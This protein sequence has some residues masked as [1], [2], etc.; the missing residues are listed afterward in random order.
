M[1]VML[2]GVALL[3]GPSVLRADADHMHDHKAATMKGDSCQMH[4]NSMQL[5]SEVETLEK[6]L[7]QVQSS[8]G[9]LIEVENKKAKLRK[10]IEQHQA[11]LKDL[12]SRL[13]G[14]SAGAVSGEKV[15]M[16]QCPM[17]CAAPQDKPGKCPKC[18]M[19]MEKVK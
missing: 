4:C 7:K 16:Y 10:H 2:V 18:G 6:E 5:Q 9:K 14:K 17:K 11:E 12:Q 13:D 1:T 3:F 8:G 19:S 15:A